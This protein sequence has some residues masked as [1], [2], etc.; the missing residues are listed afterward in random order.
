MELILLIYL[1]IVKYNL[2]DCKYNQAIILELNIND[3]ILIET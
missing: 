1:N 3:E 2:L